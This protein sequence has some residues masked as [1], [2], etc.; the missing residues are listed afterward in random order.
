MASAS[1]I[2]PNFE[3]FVTLGHMNIKKTRTAYQA[4]TYSIEESLKC[5]EILKRLLEVLE[6]RR[7]TVLASIKQRKTPREYTTIQL[8]SDDL[9]RVVAALRD[10]ITLRIANLIDPHPHALSLKNFKGLNF[11][12]ITKIPEFK[13]ILDARNNWIGHINSRYIGP[14]NP[15]VLYSERV[16]AVLRELEFFV[17]FSPEESGKTE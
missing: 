14:V 10:Y 3:R 8:P 13:E 7:K 12:A 1:E 2:N 16:V 5:G 17:V 4:V 6:S 11:L 15:K 9:G